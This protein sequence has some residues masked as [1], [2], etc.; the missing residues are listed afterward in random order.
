QF[1]NVNKKYPGYVQAYGENEAQMIKVGSWAVSLLPFLDKHELFEMWMDKANTEA[2]NR[3]GGGHSR[4][5]VPFYPKLSVFTCASDDNPSE[6]RGPCSFGCNT[7]F[8]PDDQWAV[9]QSLNA[10]ELLRRCTSPANGVFSNQLP[11][12]VNCVYTGYEWR[13]TLGSRIDAPTR[14]ADI[15]DGQTSTLAFAEN[16]AADAWSYV[17]RTSAWLTTTIDGRTYGGDCLDPVQSP[18][19]HIGLVWLNRADPPVANVM[20]YQPVKLSRY[21]G[22]YKISAETARPQSAHSGLFYA[23]MLGGNAQGISEEIDYRVYQ[24]LM[25]PDDTSADI[26]DKAYRLTDEDLYR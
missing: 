17:G 15:R 5:N 2:W 10:H 11:K 22:R 23:V 16:Q 21:Q 18:R 26:P 6:M 24:S 14:S 8:F 13:E 19:V 20:D 4:L 7:G 12:Q 1:E 3:G 9:A 25:A